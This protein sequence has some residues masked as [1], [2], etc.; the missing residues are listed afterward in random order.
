ML[1][2]RTL[3]V[4]AD[5]PLPAPSELLKETAGAW[6]QNPG[7][8]HPLA[9]GSFLIAS[10]RDGWRHLYRYAADGTFM[11]AVTGGPW[12][13]RDVKLVTDAAA[14]GAQWVYF[15]G[16]KDSHVGENLYRVRPDGSDPA[17]LTPDDGAHSVTVSPSGEYFFDAWSAWDTP[18]HSQLRRG[19]GE[20]VRT[21]GVA[22]PKDVDK[23]ALGTFEWVE[24]P[25][26]DGGTLY[27]YVLLPPGL[28]Q[29]DP[30]EKVPAWVT[31]YGGPHTPTVKDGWAAGRSWEQLLASNGIAVLRVDPRAASGRGWAA[32]WAA[33]KQLGVQETAD[34][35]DAAD[36][37]AAQ[38][39]C[40]GSR[41]GLD[42]HSYGGYLTARVLTHTDKYAAG[43][44]GGSVTS[45]RNYDTIYTERLMDTPQANPGGYD[46]TDLTESA[47]DLSG[48]LLLI[49]GVRDDNV[50]VQNALQFAEALQRADQEFEMMLYPTARH[51]I[52]GTH[53]RRLK[54]EFIRETMLGDSDA[55][56][57]PDGPADRVE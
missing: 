22:D 4:P 52:G 51:G 20:S 54:W 26:R 48:R 8:L 47:G 24:I 49:H 9:D 16:T 1:S 45:F 50:H 5:G 56:A 46:L 28:D 35:A 37:L 29:T 39:W 36:W 21:L 18:A 23:F 53:Y 13:V 27:G 38:S 15:T 11:N 57:A 2:V 31:T 12:E 34:M 10:T 3:P 7:D 17:R 33:H 55:A 19:D 44:A 14:P 41:V 42:G 43:I 40:D 32:A 30:K 25:T 6:V